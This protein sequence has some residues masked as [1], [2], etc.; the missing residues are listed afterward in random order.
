MEIEVNDSRELRVLVV[1]DN[2][3]AC[4]L[5][6][7]A[8]KMYGIKAHSVMSA[9]QAIDAY[10]QWQPDILISDIAMPN[11]DG[12]SLLEQIQELDAARAHSTPA[13]AVTA[14]HESS[15]EALARGF[16][17][18]LPKPIDIDELIRTIAI[19]VERPRFYRCS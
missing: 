14:L 15:D 12:Y 19:L 4:D 5:M 10:L 2:E 1:D 18:F 16:H 17:H 6:E 13:I 7:L 8:L 3:D 11:E 9:Q